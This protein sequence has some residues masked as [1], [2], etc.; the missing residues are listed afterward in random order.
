MTLPSPY[1]VPDLLDRLSALVVAR[2]LVVFARIEFS[3]DAT[4][5]GL[6]LSPMAQLVFG[7]P[8]GGTPVLAAAPLAGLEL[9]LR[10]LAWTDADANVWLSYVDPAELQDRYALPDSQAAGL[11]IIHE[12]CLHAVA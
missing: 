9:P 8:R 1:A 6:T 3:H 12:L 2:E 5:A 11:Q 10:A 4:A 7:H